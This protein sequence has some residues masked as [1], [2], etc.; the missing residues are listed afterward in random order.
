MHRKGLHIDSSLLDSADDAETAGIVDSNTDVLVEATSR[1]SSS[2][3]NED[4]KLQVANKRQPAST[5]SDEKPLELISVHDNINNNINDTVTG[6]K[7]T[8][9]TSISSNFIAKTP[10]IASSSKD[11]QLLSTHEGSSTVPDIAEKISFNPTKTP[12]MCV[13]DTF[14]ATTT[15]AV[16]VTA[17]TTSS[18]IDPT[19]N[20]MMTSELR[21]IRQQL[22]YNELLLAEQSQT[23]RLLIALEQIIKVFH[24]NDQSINVTATN[25]TNITGHV[26]TSNDMNKSTAIDSSNIANNTTTHINTSTNIADFLVPKNTHEIDLNTITDPSLTTGTTINHLLLSRLHSA[27]SRILELEVQYVKEQNLRK[28]YQFQLQKVILPLSK[29]IV[30]TI[31]NQN[32]SNSNDHY[33]EFCNESTEHSNL[34]FNKSNSS[35]SFTPATTN[36]NNTSTASHNLVTIQNKRQKI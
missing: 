27:E 7:S 32:P 34:K 28:L 18:D 31:E 12:N 36:I 26:T 16:V 11:Q 3:S 10:V 4:N 35:S 24:Q 2:Q 17:T 20:N 25:N 8:Q 33:N 23:E 21:P 6:L 30:N 9:S 15:A 29:D 5:S 1:I 19:N 14:T 22:H 13:A